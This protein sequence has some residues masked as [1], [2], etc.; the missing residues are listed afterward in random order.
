[1]QF[2]GLKR[3]EFIT[4]A[5][6]AVIAWPL[7]ARAQ[8]SA[9]P[10]IGLLHASSADSRASHATAFR[11]GL[12]EAGY[13]EGQN[14][15]IQYRWADDH[16]E[17]LPDLA[18]DL[19]RR[20]VTMIVA[21]P[22]PAAIAAKKATSEIPIVFEIGADPVTLGLV[23]SLGR[24]GGNVTGIVN[25]SNTLVPKRVEMIH[26]VVP[27]AKQIAVLLNPDNQNFPLWPKM[28]RVCKN[29]L[30]SRLKSCM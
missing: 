11:F 3:R 5:S 15:G 14:V 18:A 16:Y 21:A 2:V 13:Y 12:S 4:F 1:M 28:C 24:P 26:E 20:N 7:A 25:L 17:R 23:A 10:V 6:S 27:A 19:V 30:A 29:L 9:M 22:V 8:Q